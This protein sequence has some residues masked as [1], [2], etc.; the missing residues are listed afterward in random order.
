MRQAIFKQL[1][2]GLPPKSSRQWKFFL[3]LS[4]M[5]TTLWSDPR[6]EGARS[7]SS[8]KQCLHLSPLS[9]GKISLSFT[10]FAAC[11]WK[12]HFYYRNFRNMPW[13]GNTF[14]LFMQR[15][16]SDVS[17]ATKLSL[18]VISS[19]LISSSKFILSPSASYSFRE[20]FHKFWKKVSF[21]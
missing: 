21:Y 13:Y 5:H 19:K 18:V 12:M 7:R 2:I 3:W 16:G 14:V 1:S 4:D 10:A 15:K 17:I 9:K 11:S 20:D 8:D 6:V